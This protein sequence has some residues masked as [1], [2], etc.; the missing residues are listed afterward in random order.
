MS[1]NE[2]ELFLHRSGHQPT[3]VNGRLTETLRV[4]LER[5]DVKPGG[6]DH[7]FVFV[8][9]CDDA[10]KASDGIGNGADVHVAADPDLTLDELALEKHRHVHCHRCR[11]IDATVHFEGKVL[12]RKFSP[13]AT[14]ESATRWCRANLRLDPAAA[15]EF[16]LQLSDTTDQPRPST[17]LGELVEHGECALSFELVKELTPQG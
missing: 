7:P 12:N 10:V 17:H 9:E 8:G 4:L 16:V 13:A 11:V 6:V 14:I 2:I 1:A 3:V 15:S 5:V